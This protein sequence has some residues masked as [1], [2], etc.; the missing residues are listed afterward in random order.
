MNPIGVL[1]LV[2]TLVAGGRE[3]SAVNLVNLLPRDRHRLYLVTTRA[4][5][6]LE[7][8]V[9][10]DVGR[11]ELKRQHLL[12]AVALYRLVTFIKLHKIQ[13]LHAHGDALFIA[14]LASFFYPFLG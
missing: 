13:I 9:K 12:D 3:R 14:V 5:G 4:Q 10:D 2:D 6:P 11:L 8:L 7:K 1:H